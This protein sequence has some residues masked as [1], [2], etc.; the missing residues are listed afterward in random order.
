[1]H[2]LHSPTLSLSARASSAA[3]LRACLS[4]RASA[5][6]PPRLRLRAAQVAAIKAGNK[7]MKPIYN[8]ITG[9]LDEA[10]EITPTDIVI[11]EGL[12]PMLD[13]K[14]RVALASATRAQAR[15]ARK[16]NARDAQ[17]CDDATQPASEG[18]RER[19]R[20]RCDRNATQRSARCDRL[21]QPPGAQHC[22]AP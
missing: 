3:S 14:V 13:E 5:P 4:P 7:V 2:T 15:R 16:R 12:H 8:H 18:A 17:P 10:E 21:R 9:M 22:A 20:T 6:P 1:M 11:F 19:D